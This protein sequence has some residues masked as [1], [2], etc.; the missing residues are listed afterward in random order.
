MMK[1]ERGNTL[2]EYGLVLSLVAILGFA[3][4]QLLGG[5]TS[6]KLSSV[7]KSE[8]PVMQLVQLDFRTP[9]S[10]NVSIASGSFPLPAKGDGYYTLAIDR[11][12]GQPVIKL[13]D[14]TTGQVTNATSI[15]GKEWNTLGSVHLASALED[16][17]KAQTDPESRRQIE[18][19]ARIAYFMG[20]CEGEIDGVPGFEAPDDYM[21]LHGL[22][23]LQT[24]QTQLLPLMQ[25]RPPGMDNQTYLEAAALA[26]DVYNISRTYTE[27]FASYIASDTNFTLPSN[28]ENG[29]GAGSPG[30][31][32]TVEP[33][34][35][36]FGGQELRDNH[37]EEY[38][39]L[40][41]VRA[42][43]EQL[44]SNNKLDS[45]PVEATFEDAVD[46]DEKAVANH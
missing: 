22:K 5:A 12:T 36:D 28:V 32:F 23:D 27:T 3:G 42:Y 37:I 34:L 13:T 44:L 19:M 31:A 29:M 39:T 38:F 1:A 14:S 8:K 21:K 18:E 15:E 40:D 41:Q 4:L 25:N 26:T 43:A 30:E 16:L 10:P 6:D 33:V 46:L 20:A 7:K 24:L 17:A 11:A 9:L 35:R 2:M 45:V